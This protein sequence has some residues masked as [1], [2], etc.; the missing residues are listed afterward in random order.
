LVLLYKGETYP[1]LKLYNAGSVP[2]MKVS[3]HLVVILS[4]NYCITMVQKRQISGR[5][6]PRKSVCNCGQKVKG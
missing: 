5:G 1:T 4:N 6:K 3:K 2:G